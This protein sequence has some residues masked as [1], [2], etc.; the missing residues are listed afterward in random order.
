MLG[1]KRNSATHT[2]LG[3]AARKARR[4]GK[5]SAISP[6]PLRHD[7][8]ASNSLT[9][10]CV[11]AKL[12][13]EGGEEL[14]GFSFGAEV[15]KAGEVVFNTGMVGYPE[16]LTDPSY[17]GQ[18]LVLTYPL[19][20]NY[21]VPND[22]EFDEYGLPAHFE[23]NNIHVN[24]LIVA[25]YSKDPSH[26]NSS[27]SLG[28]W[29]RRSGVPALFGIDTRAMTKHI[30]EHGALLG[31]I[32]FSGDPVSF[33]DPNKRNLVAEVST[34]VI[35]VFGEGNSPRILAYDCGIKYNIIRYFIDAHKVQLTLVPFDYD[36]EA[37]PEGVE[38]D[39]LFISNG[40]GDP[41]LATATIKSL[42]YAMSL[43]PPKPIFG[44]CLGNQLMALAAGAKT[45][46]MKYGNRGMNQPCVDM[47]TGKCY[48]TPQNHG[49]A[50]DTD[51]LPEGWRTFFLNANDM[52]NEGIIHLTKP[53]CSAQFHP[54]A[55][56]GP[57]DTAFLFDKFVA[58]V[59][60]QTEPL[61]LH[62]PEIYENS[63]AKVR[64]VLLVGSGALSIG[65]AGEFDYSGSQAIKALKEE[66][67]EVVLLNPNIATVQTSKDLGGASP[68]R[69]Y[70]LPVR[71][72]VVCEL[73]DKEQPDSIIVSMG[74]QTA[75]N[76]GIELWEAGELQRRGIKVL[77]TQIPVIVA[78][79]DREKFSVKLRE[80][81]ET[82]ALSF[83]ASNVDEA[84]EAAEKIGYPVLIRAAFALGG[85]GSGFAHDR[86][87]L[88]DLASKA[89]SCSSQILIDQDLRGWKEVEYEVVR[90]VRDNCITVCNMENFD[91]LGIH[92]G[93]SIVVAPSQ[94]LSNREYFKLRSTALK[95]V[96]HLGIVGEC[97]IQYALHPD[98]ERYCIIEVNARLS[99]SSALASK[100]T[101]YPLAYVAA[102]LSLGN[103][104]V[105][106]RNSVTKNTTACF[107]PSLDYLVVKMPR[108]DLKKFQRVSTDLG[109]S[110]KSVGEVMAMGR[111][112]EEC[113]QKAVRMVLPG[114]K[115]LEGHGESIKGGDLEDKLKNP[116]DERLWMVQTA[117]EQGYS[118]DRVHALT[119]IDRWFLSKLKM[120]ST[121]KMAARV[122]GNLEKLAGPEIR[123]MKVAG[124]SDSQI[125]DYTGSTEMLVRRKRTGLGI[126][127]YVKQIDTLAAEFPAATNYLYMTYMGSENDIGPEEE[128]RSV[129]VLGCGAYCIGSSV[130]FD[131]SAVSCVRELRKLGFAAIVVNYNPETVSTDFD[132]SDQLFFEELSFERVLDIYEAQSVYG[133]VV[134][135]GGQIP[136]NLAQPLQEVGVHILGTSPN[137]IN[138]AEDRNLFSAMLDSI[139]VD[140]PPW[141]SL[142][143]IEGAQ[144]WAEEHEYPVLVRPS[145]VLSGAA[146][147]VASTPEQLS[148]FLET[149]ADVSGDKPVVVSKF[150]VNAKEIEFDAVAN[151]GHILNYAISEHV[152]NA[153]VHSGDAT[154]VL[155]AQRLYVQTIRNVKRIAQKIAAALSITGPFNIQLLAKDNFVK[156]IEC[157]LRASRTFPFISKTLGV[158]FIQLATRCM[159][160]AP[161]KPYSISLLD[162]DYVGVKAPMFSFTRLRGADPTLGV[163]MAST[164]EV[165]CYGHDVHHAFMA[166]MYSTGFKK[167]PPGSTLL[168]SI[169]NDTFRNEFL[170][171]MRLLR[172]M[173]YILKCT[174]GTST[175]YRDHNLDVIGLEKPPAKGENTCLQLIT[176]GKISLV[177]NIPEGTTQRDEVT[178]GYLLRRAAVDFGVNLIT[179]LKV[180]VLLVESLK[181]VKH[182]ELLS[183]EDYQASIPKPN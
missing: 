15:S 113:I 170:P 163:E 81:N 142:D 26:W 70:T 29:L 145:F 135:V 168:V 97:N 54:E 65:Q 120:I 167:P 82:L 94:T 162:I 103:D 90:D 119:K 178:A 109:S 96:R 63:A 124:F 152:E 66:G 100:A 30:R 32:E 140:Q 160:G 144:Q 72:S 154:L 143:T 129:M 88:V 161:A 91:P 17:R 79:E 165:A 14:N 43:E 7:A 106:I 67:V 53:F 16:A 171:S 87:E 28:A 68:D 31:K 11:A 182:L 179:N 110:M 23:S 10:Q 4:L 22:D 84:I 128:R 12:V 114:S 45:S 64:K 19:V 176:S 8:E 138:R 44:I 105:S 126:V 115:G 52:T 133:V 172:E 37:N 95:V 21:G 58:Q 39:G 42:Q 123:A 6:I 13:L 116:T 148:Q 174:P 55:A 36:L 151:N 41:A 134:S 166:S 18:I 136:N 158:N 146:M 92:T 139:G 24:G 5:N 177:I 111:C 118:I 27:E 141:A 76:V 50:V 73:L 60:G 104:L 108:W 46:K 125:A 89:F 38:W 86:K 35:R 9:E 149:A 71:A 83:P 93:D 150:I 137:D 77:G 74:G 121:M 127:P 57:L 156:V 102:K 48:I 147:K 75:L 122:R 78:T 169:A 101:G 155:P 40:P 3:R 59:N 99:R 164:G 47:R 157:N 153:G 107:E 175:F 49:F 80:I 173:G 56:G 85:L 112:F 98:S 181:R 180:A 1:K 62:L 2:P 51:A 131:W 159:V 183:L 117:L 25:S 130:E 20:G 132:E 34:K 61:V 33:D 69:V